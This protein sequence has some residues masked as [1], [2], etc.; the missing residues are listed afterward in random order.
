MTKKRI[1]WKDE[2]EKLKKVYDEIYDENKALKEGSTKMKIE[3]G[4]F[5]DFK[6]VFAML[7]KEVIE[8]A[9]DNSEDTIREWARDE[10]EELIDDL[11]ISR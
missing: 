11:S 7:F 5:E 4:K 8:E 3:L 1:S 10:A 2:F 9:I 6:S